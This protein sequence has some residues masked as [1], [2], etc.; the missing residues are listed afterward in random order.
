MRLAGHVFY[1]S[2]LWKKEGLFLTEGWFIYLEPVNGQL[3]DDIID[4]LA[5]ENISVMDLSPSLNDQGKV[6]VIC[7][8]M[9]AHIGNRNVKNDI[10]TFNN[11]CKNLI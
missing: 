7:L 2:G 4:S 3:P 10:I 6:S 9:A 8:S 1:E 5:K 11:V